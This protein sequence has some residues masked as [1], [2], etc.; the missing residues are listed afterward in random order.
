[1]LFTTALTAFQPPSTVVIGCR[2]PARTSPVALQLDGG[3]FL[4]D[5][6]KGFSAGFNTPQEEIAAEVEEQKEETQVAPASPS[7]VDPALAARRAR[8]EFV[9]QTIRGKR[10][11]RVKRMQLS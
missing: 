6:A 3:G 11:C 2:P 10:S 7:P 9:R 8:Q 4:K 5:L 1:M